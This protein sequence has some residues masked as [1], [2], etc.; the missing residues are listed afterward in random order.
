MVD[1]QDVADLAESLAEET[2]RAIAKRDLD[3]ALGLVVTLAVDAGM[4]DFASITQQ[5][6]GGELTTTAPT[7]ELVVT[8]DKL[9]YL[10]QEGPCVSAVYDDDVLVSPEVD[11]DPRWPR[12]GPQ[13][14][15]MGLH[16]IVSVHLYTDV[17]AMGALNLYSA[18]RREY[19]RDEL[20][21]ARLVGA[22]ASVALAHFRGQAH[23]WKAIDARHSVGIAQGIVM[24]QFGVGAELAFGILRRL[25]Q[26]TNIKLH[27]VAAEVVRNGRLPPHDT[28]RDSGRQ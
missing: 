15:T 27:L 2:R 18:H 4:C 10:L 22:H 13:A 19:S 24:H 9:Q 11:I 23:L 25:S 17:E 6:P 3:V 21:V 20:D 14:V 28:H 16:S 7:D 1:A 8:A 26:D 5:L 12:W